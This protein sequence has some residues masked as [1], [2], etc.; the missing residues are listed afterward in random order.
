MLVSLL[1]TPVPVT[2]TFTP[3]NAVLSPVELY[4]EDEDRPTPDSK[5]VAL[6]AVI[7]GSVVLDPYT[8]IS[9]LAV[10]VTPAA[11]CMV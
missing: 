6:S 4:G 3:E 5:A 9:K 7:T 8:L 11:S 10:L 1:K 2:E